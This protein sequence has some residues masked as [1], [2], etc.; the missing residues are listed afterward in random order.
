MV[1]SPPVSSR[2]GRG[3][4]ELRQAGDRKVDAVIEVAI[5]PRQSTGQRRFHE[6][7]NGVR[8]SRQR[9]QLRHA[10][11]LVH[12]A[13]L[14]ADLG[15]GATEQR[16]VA[17]EIDRDR[18][19]RASGSRRNAAA[20]EP[21]CRQ[22]Q[23]LRLPRAEA[24]LHLFGILG[25][26]GGELECFA[27]EHGRR[28]VMLAATL[29]VR[30]ER[31]HDVRSDRPDQP[32][33]ITDDFI[34]SPFLERLFEAERETEIDGARE[35]L[36]GAVEAVHGG[37]LLGAQHAE[38][39]EDLRPDLVLPAVS[40]CRRRQR[41]PEAQALVQQDEERIVFVVG[42]RRRVHEDAGIRQ[43][44]QRQAERHVSLLLVE[45]DDAHLRG[46]QGGK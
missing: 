16:I 12:A 21:L 33:E 42:V 13:R 7:Q 32:D 15:V 36:F 2:G 11:A 28:L 37:K 31:Q 1:V 10:L 8:W 40:A 38:R 20:A 9:Q 46:G 18:R 4:G 24:G 27:G 41:G 39:F 43:A 45:R 25:R 26:I 17:G 29:S 30:T 6:L 22:V 44:P 5:R 14:G 35:V 23:L 19:G 34:P 3:P